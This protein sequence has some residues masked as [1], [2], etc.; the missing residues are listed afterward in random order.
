MTVNIISIVLACAALAVS[1]VVAR[2]QLKASRNSDS[3]TAMLELFREYREDDLKKA[4]RVVFRIPAGHGT[5]SRL[6]EMQGD[7]REASERVAHFLRPR[8][9]SYRI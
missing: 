6:G 9:P 5:A 8:R 4:R 7:A 3:V 2:G 1:I